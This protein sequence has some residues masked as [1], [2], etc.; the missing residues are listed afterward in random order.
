MVPLYT[1][2]VAEGLGNAIS[3]CVYEVQSGSPSYTATLRRAIEGGTFPD[4]LLNKMYQ[5]V[6]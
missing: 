2:A 4:F 3:Y 6:I 5:A 1:I